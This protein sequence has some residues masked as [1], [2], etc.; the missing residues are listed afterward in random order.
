MNFSK[1]SPKKL[2]CPKFHKIIPSSRLLWTKSTNR[3]KKM[4][5]NHQVV[6]IRLKGPNHN[7]VIQANL[8]SIQGALYPF[9][10]LKWKKEP[11]LGSKFSISTKHPRI[12]MRSKS[13]CNWKWPQSHDNFNFNLK[14]SLKSKVHNN[15]IIIQGLIRR[16]NES[17]WPS[18]VSIFL[19]LRGKTSLFKYLPLRGHL[20]KSLGMVLTHMNQIKSLKTYPT[21]GLIGNKR[22]LTQ[23]I[24]KSTPDSVTTKLFLKGLHNWAFFQQGK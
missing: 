17:W 23:S 3:Q 21:E 5:R 20:H 2:C 11:P 9:H 13:G 18:P 14:A 7:L 15:K 6:W 10:L 12:K 19:S 16:T 8:K 22:S 4:A 1:D 24:L